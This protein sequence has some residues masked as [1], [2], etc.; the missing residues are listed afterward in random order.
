MNKLALIWKTKDLRNKIL[1][2][3]GLL[4]LTRVLA[5]VPIPG[6]DPTGLRNFFQTNQFLNLIDIFS[7]GDVGLHVAKCLYIYQQKPIEEKKALKTLEE[8]VAYLQQCYQEG[9]S[10]YEADPE[11]KAAIDAINKAI[12]QHDPEVLADW[13]ETRSWSVEYYKEFEK[14]IGT[15]YDRYYFES[16]TSNAGIDLVKKNTDSVFEESEGA[17]V[18]RGEQYGLHTRVFLTKHGTPTYEAKDIGLI[19]MKHSEWPFDKAIVTT[20]SEQ[21]AYWQVVKKAIELIF[22]ELEGK[23]MHFGFGMIDLK[24]GKMSSRTGNIVSAIE[25]VEIVKDK[26]LKELLKNDDEKAAEVIAVGAV[27]YAFLKSEAK[28]NMLFDM[29]QSVSVQG[30]SGPYL[31]YT[32]ARL[33]SVL[34]KADYKAKALPINDGDTLTAEDKTILHLLPT[35]QDVVMQA[36][37]T[38]APHLICTYVYELAQACNLLYDKQSIL[39]ASPEEKEMRLALI[40]AASL[41]IKTSLDLLGIKVLERI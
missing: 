40:E 30:N 20:A 24:G 29:E 39:K 3:M 8:K 36:G 25:L 21:N 38:Y 4:L 10:A 13:E 31:Q 41:T 2:V 11:A 34:A 37:E 22:P 1:I 14:R 23:I 15:T 35:F 26:V 19:N 12:Y 17:I 27:K 28:K 9:S 18:F 16:E 6:I 7:G 32:Y 33:R 5:H